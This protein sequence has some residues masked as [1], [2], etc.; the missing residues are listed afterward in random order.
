MEPCNLN[1]RKCC[2]ESN[3]KIISQGVHETKFSFNDFE[4]HN[5][6]DNV[7]VECN[8]TFCQ[9]YDKTPACN[10]V[11]HAKRQILDLPNMSYTFTKT[12]SSPVFIMKQ[13]KTCNLIS[14]AI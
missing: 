2:T 3:T 9:K 7:Y 5:S 11:C 4:F 1:Y 13:A 8:A 12:G 14:D 10:Q 6:K